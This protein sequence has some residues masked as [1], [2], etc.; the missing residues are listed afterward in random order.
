VPRTDDA[1]RVGPVAIET[2]GLTKR[3][4]SRVAVDGLDLAVPA[5]AVTGFVGPNGAGKTTTIRMLLGLI[6]PTAG[7]GRVLG[8][9]LDD[10]VAFLPRVGALVDGP[11]H[12][13]QL[14]GR[15][16]LVVLARLAGHDGR[17]QRSVE[18]LGHGAHGWRRVGVSEVVFLRIGD[19]EVM[20]DLDLKE[21][22]V[23]QLRIHRPDVVI[24]HDPF[25]PYSLHSDHRGVGMSTVDAVYP[26]ARDPL[27]YHHHLTEEGLEPHKTAELW[28]ANP[29]VPDLYVD[30]TETVDKKI[31]ALK[32]HK[33][34]V[35]DGEHLDERIRQRTADVGAPEG[36]A[37]AEAFKVIKMRR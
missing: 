1:R 23:R 9:P 34:Q 24:T 29:E 3:Y 17:V 5:G 27:H 25:R 36:L 11:A 20:P 35:G 15:D 2:A 13:L 22:I 7:S 26:T 30:I 18:H 12:Y 19:G 32:A 4:G 28:L 14:S 33:S 8:Q 10:A 37:H 6:R 31:Y 16:N 21:K